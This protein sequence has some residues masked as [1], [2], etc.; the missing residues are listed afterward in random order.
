[1]SKAVREAGRKHLTRAGGPG[2]ALA[3]GGGGLGGMGWGH[4]Q[5]GQ[6]EGGGLRR[7][8]EMLPTAASAAPDLGAVLARSRLLRPSRSSAL[9]TEQSLGGA[10]TR[11]QAG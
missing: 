3:Q 1:M 5:R 4:R 7:R 10:R 8:D 11:P 2:A 6:R 9:H